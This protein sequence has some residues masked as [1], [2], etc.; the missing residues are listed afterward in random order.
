MSSRKVRI[1]IVGGRFGSTFQFHEHP[2]CTVEAVSDF[3][4][5]QRKVLMETYRCNKSYVTL[6]EIIKDKDVDAVAIFTPAPFHARHSIA[7]LKAGKHVFCAVPAVMNLEEAEELKE[8]VEKTGLIYMMAETSYYHQSVISARKWY[9]EGKFGEIFYTE[10]EYYHPGLDVLFFENGQRTWRYGF[11]PMHYPTHCTSYLIGVT[12]ERLT[13]VTC[14]GWGDDSQVLKDNAYNNPFW[15]ETAFFKTDKGHAFRVAIYWNAPVRGCERGQWCGTKMSFYDP[16]PNGLGPVIVRFSEEVEKDGK[17]GVRKL[18]H[19][20]QYEQE[21]WWKTDMLPEPLR[22][23]S[24]HDGS[25]TFLTHEFID[26]IV[27]ERT[28]AIGINEALAYTVPGIIAHKSA[29]EGGRQ[30]EIPQF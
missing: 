24:G 8:T 19:L 14:V 1:G 11:P 29:L 4:P 15:N 18:P 6:D 7:A 28:P 17:G 10:A 20:E 13:S 2:N 22:H 25:H 16:H 27:N 5:D 23:P 21:I 9:K 12:G 30:L 3:N 26:A